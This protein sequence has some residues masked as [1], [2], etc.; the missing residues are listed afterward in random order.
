[1]EAF[2]GGR[3][4]VDHSAWVRQAR[5]GVIEEWQRAVAAEQIVVCPALLAE[6][7]HSAVNYDAYVE[8]EEELTEGFDQLAFDERTWELAFVAQRQLAA[9]AATYHRRPVADL[10]TAAAAHQH[11]LGVL[12]YDADFDLI[13]RYTNLAFESRWLA[14]RSTLD[15]P[16]ANPRRERVRAVTARLAQFPP[17]SWAEAHDAVIDLLDDRIAALDLDPVTP[18]PE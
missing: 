8:I 16:V 7:L 1:M 6:A 4:L 15:Q 14:Q 9:V 5:S 13:A 12:H 2:G 18:P 10:L 17:E 3:F 11:G